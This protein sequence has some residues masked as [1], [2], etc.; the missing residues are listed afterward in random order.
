[1]SSV[2]TVPIFPTVFGSA[3]KIYTTFSCVGGP[4]HVF[5][6]VVLAV[7]AIGQA[8]LNAGW[9]LVR[10]IPATGTIG[11][12]FGIGFAE[13]GG[14][15]GIFNSV[16]WLN[17]ACTVENVTYFW[18]DPL[19]LF[20]PNYPPP[21][22]NGSYVLVDFNGGLAALA[23]AIT[24]DS[25]FDAS[26]TDATHLLLVAKLPINPL[27]VVFGCELQI[28][29]DPLGENSAGGN[30]T[31]AGYVF[32]SGDGAS[33][34][35]LTLRYF[36]GQGP[37]FL[38]DLNGFP[39]HYNL[40]TEGEYQMIASEYQFAIFRTPGDLL[41]FNSTLFAC[42]PYVDPDHAPGVHYC[43]FVTDSLTPRHSVIQN[44]PGLPAIGGRVTV[45]NDV[46]DPPDPTVAAFPVL[47][48]YPLVLYGLTGPITGEGGA[49]VNTIGQTVQ[50]S[51]F[52]AVNAPGLTSPETR[53][54][55]YIWDT[56][57]ES[58]YYVRGTIMYLDGHHWMSL[59]QN[60]GSEE[61][62]TVR[63]TLWIAID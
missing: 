13:G 44:S 26:V 7:R 40:G 30:A 55:G 41:T 29:G 18:Y 47:G 24:A 49:L 21:G 52:L 58:E 63:A 9:N 57:I 16:G 17:A 39:F 4:F 31:G 1:M 60:D 43:A 54:V 27:D 38:F 20:N 51:A 10:I 12:P 42:A 15:A 22:F 37:D 23:S 25:S 35:K 3:H 56:M 48:A 50:Q 28:G 59:A 36:A 62:F 11:W 6:D 19:S 14:P 45:V 53:I 33:L 5:P 34:I 46:C 32:Y 61:W 2:F 8:L